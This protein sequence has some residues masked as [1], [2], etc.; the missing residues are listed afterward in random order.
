MFQ[1][2]FSLSL[3]L[4]Q[5]TEIPSC[6][7]Y[8]LCV[9]P[10]GVGFTVIPSNQ[11]SS[12]SL[13]LLETLLDIV[14]P[15]P[16]ITRLHLIS[17]HNRKCPLHWQMSILDF[18]RR[19]TCFSLQTFKAFDTTEMYTHLLYFKCQYLYMYILYIYM[20]LYIYFYILYFFYYIIFYCK[21][22]GGPK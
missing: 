16:W 1:R 14:I 21:W 17:R 10:A 19:V 6:C 8:C 9:G 20:F 3:P 12:K 7:S 18:E 15:F 2:G 4:L 11:P 13:K 22:Q 5:F